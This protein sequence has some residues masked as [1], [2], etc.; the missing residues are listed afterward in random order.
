MPDGILSQVADV[1]SAPRRGLWSALGLPEYGNQ[2]LAQQFGMD[3]NSLL[4]HALGMG[5]EVL[6][7]PLTWAGALAAPAL[8]RGITAL[9][10]PAPQLA[11]AAAA[12]GTA[13]GQ[14]EMLQAAKAAAQ[15]GAA[16]HAAAK[17]A[18]IQQHLD[19]AKGFTGYDIPG[20]AGRQGRDVA[21]A[22]MDAANELTM[23]NLAEGAGPIGIPQQGPL[24]QVA[25]K[26]GADA[27]N[28][29]PP[30]YMPPDTWHGLTLAGRQ[31]AGGLTR[32]LP[33]G[34][35][36]ED[37]RVPAGYAGPADLRGGQLAGKR[38]VRA[39]GVYP[40]VIQDQEL[41][42]LQQRA[43]ALP[44]GWQALESIHEPTTGTGLL[45]DVFRGTGENFA[46]KI[47][48]PSLGDQLMGPFPQHWDQA[49]GALP[50][51]DKSVYEAL[52]HIEPDLALALSRKDAADAALHAAHQATAA[53]TMS[54]W[55]ERLMLG[56]AGLGA[57][58]G[59]MMGSEG[60]RRR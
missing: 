43:A 60:M 21:M 13:G 40:P 26:V 6:T 15:R 52:G 59:G 45:R 57:Y 41:A 27:F 42:A 30:P 51:L 36:F 35:S 34:F 55:E 49:M 7:D 14:V 9:R 12:A 38:L 47:P 22:S 28:M 31:R 48:A 50:N 25:G 2:L 18:M 58:S 56:G 19:R 23:A 17:E 11:E 10:T 46:R 32:P 16:E 33:P 4:T 44:G 29:P 20:I 53:R 37:V 54:P 1:L 24:Q 3:P 39:P 5:A 8:A